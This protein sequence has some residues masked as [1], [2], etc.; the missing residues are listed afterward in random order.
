MPDEFDQYARKPQNSDQDEFAQYARPSGGDFSGKYPTQ[1]DH[2]DEGFVAHATKT[3]RDLPDA[4]LSGRMISAPLESLRDSMG[5]FVQNP[6]FHN[7]VRAIPG[8][9]MA[10][11]AIMQ[12]YRTAQSGDTAGAFGDAAD[13]GAQI[14]GLREAG[15]RPAEP[16]RAVQVPGDATPLPKMNPFVRTLTNKI[17]PVAGHMLTGAYDAAQERGMA[18]PGRSQSRIY[19]PAM[20]VSTSEGPTTIPPSGTMGNGPQAGFSDFRRSVFHDPV[21]TNLLMPTRTGSTPGSYPRVE[22]DITPSPRPLMRSDVL[23]VWSGVRDSPEIIPHPLT[24]PP[25]ALPSGRSVGG[26]RNQQS[27]PPAPIAPVAP[28]GTASTGPVVF[29]K[30]Y[31]QGTGSPTTGGTPGSSALVNANA[32]MM[33][34]Q[35]LKNLGARGIVNPDDAVEAIEPRTFA[36]GGIKTNIRRK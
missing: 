14:L 7:S 4:F 28:S 10:E 26:I 13:I 18:I 17:I 30:T 20:D 22:G 31:R 29:G 32:E 6:T 16:L 9:A 24:P 34:Q 1:P 21:D 11:D 3:I 8:V 5:S 23:P 35:R 33:R 36:N 15:I 12:P 19:G 2:K 25:G 27:A